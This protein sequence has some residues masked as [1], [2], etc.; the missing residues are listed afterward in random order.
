[1]DGPRAQVFPDEAGEHRFRLVSAND[2]PQ[3]QSEGYAGGADAAERGARD[4]AKSFMLGC[5]MPP[6]LAEQWAQQLAVEFL[7]A[8]G[9]T[10][11][12]SADEDGD[13]G[14][15]DGEG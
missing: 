10:I 4:A 3:V 1:M 9:E 8:D 11:E 12:E 14:D 2:E 5:R 15:G 7:D 13:D 6:H